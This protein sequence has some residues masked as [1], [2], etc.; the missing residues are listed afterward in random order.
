[1][2][3]TKEKHGKEDKNKKEELKDCWKFTERIHPGEEN[4][5]CAP[6]P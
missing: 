4:M 1:M 5:L 2:R 3:N 6:T